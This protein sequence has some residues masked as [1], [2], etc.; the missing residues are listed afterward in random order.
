MHQTTMKHILESQIPLLDDRLNHTGTWTDEREV[1]LCWRIQAISKFKYMD[2][3]VP[4]DQYTGSESELFRLE[5]LIAFT[6]RRAVFY[7]IQKPDDR[8]YIDQVPAENWTKLQ[9][10]DDSTSLNGITV[11]LQIFQREFRSARNEFYVEAVER[12]RFT[13]FYVVAEDAGLSFMDSALGIP[14]EFTKEGT[15]RVIQMSVQFP[16]ASN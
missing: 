10:S 9:L 3:N 7:S 15:A 1:G 6:D 4:A 2:K 12:L 11:A 13:D 16:V 14:T 5:M 8:M